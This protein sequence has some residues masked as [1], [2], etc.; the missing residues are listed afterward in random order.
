MNTE[1]TERL[2]EMIRDRLRLSGGEVVV[3]AYAGVGTFAA[4][5]A[6]SSRKVIA[7]EESTAAV[8]DAAINTLGLD[9]IVL[10]AK[11][12]EEALDTLD[13]E[14]DAVILDPPR[15][16]CHPSGAGS[17]RPTRAGEGR[18]RL[19]RSGDPGQGP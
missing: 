3:D 8:R 9:N 16:G 11:K 12:T 19:L 13:E 18:I 7:I 15:A 1:Q 4:L 5:F 17:P 2:A 6:P 14:P 10:V